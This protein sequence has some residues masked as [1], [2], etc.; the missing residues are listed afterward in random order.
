MN[1]ENSLRARGLSDGTTISAYP[2]NVW[3]GIFDL[4]TKPSNLKFFYSKILAPAS[5]IPE[6]GIKFGPY[7]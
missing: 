1:E 7:G 6:I 4:S 3:R 2:I 5:I